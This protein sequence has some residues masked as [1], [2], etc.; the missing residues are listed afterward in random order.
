MTTETKY[1]QGDELGYN[2]VDKDYSGSMSTREG[3]LANEGPYNFRQGWV[4][5][6]CSASV[7]PQN[8]I[9]PNCQTVKANES[10]ITEG[11]QILNG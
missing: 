10:R 9:C 2:K 4:C 1:Q 5:P 7:A 8:D 3:E 11:K 6:Q